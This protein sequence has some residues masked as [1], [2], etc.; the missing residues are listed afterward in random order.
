V[1]RI[2]TF[3]RISQGIYRVILTTDDPGILPA[4]RLLRGVAALAEKLDR[5]IDQERRVLRL[6]DDRQASAPEARAERA[7]LLAIYRELPG[8]RGARIKQLRRILLDTYERIT[9]DDV[10]A[11]IS[12]ATAEE[13]ISRSAR[14]AELAAGGS[15]CREIGAILR[16][17]P[18]QAARLAHPEPQG[19]GDA[20]KC[21]RIDDLPSP[22]YRGAVFPIERDSAEKNHTGRAL[23][24]A[25]TPPVFAGSP[26]PGAVRGR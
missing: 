14:A 26:I 18:A 11:L 4:L 6:L 10:L 13:R 15:S 23:P 22:A 20:L 1:F 17:S 21:P 12:R 9:Y 24:E 3:S 2:E 8:S 7:K 5:R 19:N 16:I 25:T